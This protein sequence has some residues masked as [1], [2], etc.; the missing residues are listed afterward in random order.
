MSQTD[1]LREALEQA[2]MENPDDVASHMAYADYLRDQGD[3]RGE[4][5][6]VQLA[7]EDPARKGAERKRLKKREEEL[8]DAHEREWLGELAP[9]LLSTPEEELELARAESTVGWIEP[10]EIGYSWAR[11]WLDRVECRYLTVEMARKLGRA[12][13][14]RLLH[15][16]VW[17]SDRPAE[18]FRYEGGPDLPE[19]ENYFLPYEVLAHYPAAR[20]LRV[21]QFG[22]EVDPDEWEYRSRTQF[23]RLSPLVQ[24]MPR[25]E[26]LHV[27]AR[28][29]CPP[30]GGRAEMRRLVS[31][32]TL[33]HLRIFEHYHGWF[34]PLEE[35]ASNPALGRLTHLL[36]YPSSQARLDG[37]GTG[38]A[39]AIS[40]AGV[41]A[42]V[43]SPHLTSLTHLQLRCCDGG[44]EMVE[45]LIY[46]GVLKRLKM[47]DLRH[48]RVS[49]DGAK[50]LAACPEVR[51][52]EI[53]LVNNRLTDKGIAALQVAG[54]RLES[55]GQQTRPYKTSAMFRGD[56]D[57]E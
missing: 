27:F 38:W 20:N 16:L 10:P 50:L 55:D 14:A 35:L 43:R 29:T 11:G 1:P 53:D 26:E 12:P 54:A 52:M 47:L 51:G 9:L 13:I 33:T 19:D 2:L 48:G 42:V 46:S 22:R 7:L 21:F 37:S 6:Q 34:Y 17:R 39:A 25:L 32:P 31:L 8:L 56:V 41:R 28:C 4:L 30:D 3:P 5:I 57:Y 18:Y 45:D 40:R 36:C 24:R 23:P 15:G 49:D 44:D